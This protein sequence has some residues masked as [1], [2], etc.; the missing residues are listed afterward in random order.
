MMLEVEGEGKMLGKEA[1][2]GGVTF[3]R[4]GRNLPL[5]LMIGSLL[6]GCLAPAATTITST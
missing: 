2:Q 6:V 5:L 4:A 1:N 3:G